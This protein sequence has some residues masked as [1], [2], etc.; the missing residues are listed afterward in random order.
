VLLSTLL[1]QTS[2]TL[3]MLGRH[4]CIESI[5]GPSNVYIHDET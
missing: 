4:G 5:H 3:S 2:S 1:S